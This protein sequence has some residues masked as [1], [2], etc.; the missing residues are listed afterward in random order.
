MPIGVRC[1]AAAAC[2]LSVSGTV[3]AQGR[4]RD[5]PRELVELSSA[6]LGELIRNFAFEDL[7]G[8]TAHLSDTAGENALVIALRS[9]LCPVSRRYGSTLARLEKAYR[10]KGVRFLFLNASSQ[11]SIESM[12][13]EITRFGFE[14]PYVQDLEA[15]FAKILRATTTT[16]VFVVD[17]AH[18]LRYRGAIDDQYGIGYSKATP[19]ADYLDDAL[20]DL[21]AGRELRVEATTAPGCVL[22]L[23]FEADS[24]P[25]KVTYHNRVSRI[26]QNNCVVCHRDGGAGP[27]P[28]ESYGHAK[29][30][31]SMISFVVENEVMPPWFAAKSVGSWEND[32]RLSER[33]RDALLQW[34]EAGSPEGDPADAPLPRLYSG[35]WSIRTPDAVFE[36]EEPFQVPAEGVVDYQYVYVKTDFDEDKWV[37]EMEILPTAPQVTH[38][39]LVFIEEPGRKG[40][41]DKT[42]K[43]GEPIFQGGLAGYFAST[44]PG[45]QPTIFPEG[46]AKLL[47]KGAWL[48]FQV[49]YTPNGQPATD[50]T[51]LGIVFADEPPLR[52]VETG[53][54]FDTRFEIPPGAANYAVTGTYAF[55][56]DTVVTSFFPHM[57]LRAKAFRYELIYPDG[58]AETILDIPRYDFNWQLHYKLR[59]PKLVPKGTV[60][61]STGWFDNSADNPA[62]P[63]P[64]ASVRFGEQTFEE[65]MIGYF[66]S[67]DPHPSSEGTNHP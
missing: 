64:T 62:N 7:D 51:R 66:D 19:T 38:H 40:G 32:R 36:I 48:K 56:K 35:G 6:R 59:E 12:R 20:E 61:R 42:R 27:F 8:E 45:Q 23:S 5:A 3:L 16:E 11:D 44:V 30:F 50:Q 18:T 54:A 29:G 9:V 58:S 39:V 37:Q 2:L 31:A 26:L 28:L 57:H 1:V 13:D 10:P 24:E 52:A 63:D 55:E 60:L 17:R 34:I 15:V 21:L 43:P 47:P 25:E 22:G 46:T 67:Y 53:A 14:G 41:R 49:H 33:E 4:F 65:M